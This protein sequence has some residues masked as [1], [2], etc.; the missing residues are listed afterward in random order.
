MRFCEKKFDNIVQ[1]FIKDFL[2][3]L[4]ILKILDFFPCLYTTYVM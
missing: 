1:I 2:V 4:Q 3:H